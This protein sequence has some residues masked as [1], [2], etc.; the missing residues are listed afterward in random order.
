[1]KQF[2][3]CFLL[4]IC[5]RGFSQSRDEITVRQ[6]LDEQTKAWNR[7]DLEGFMK[8]YWQSDSLTFIGRSGITYGW[9]STLNNYRKGYPDTA[10]MGKLAFDIV[11]VK[12][13]SFQY[14]FATGKWYLHRGIGDVNG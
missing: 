1:M 4:L 6:M 11:S 8:G 7:G 9:Q 5:F 3:L 12:R 10:T 14:F 2:L 13:L